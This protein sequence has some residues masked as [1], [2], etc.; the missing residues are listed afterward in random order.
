MVSASFRIDR[1]C[2]ILRSEPIHV[3]ALLNRDSS[4]TLLLRKS[5]QRGRRVKTLTSA[6]LTHREPARRE[7][8]GPTQ[9]MS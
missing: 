4:P 8:F 9:Q 3:T 7:A 5:Y 6:N 2:P 1:K